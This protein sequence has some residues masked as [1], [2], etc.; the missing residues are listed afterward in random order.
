M[1]IVQTEYIPAV[2]NISLTA[3]L[4]PN[5]DLEDEIGDSKSD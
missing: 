4:I 5:K 3:N 1:R 2:G